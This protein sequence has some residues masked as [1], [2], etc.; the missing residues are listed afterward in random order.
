MACPAGYRPSQSLDRVRAE[1]ADRLEARLPE[2]GE[3][4]LCRLYAISD[5]TDAQ[6]AEYRE[7]LR[8]AMSAAIEYAL[9]AIERGQERSGP[10]PAAML[11]QARSAARN[12]VGLEVVLRRYAAGYSALSDFLMQETGRDSVRFPA[13]ELYPMQ[14][15]LTAL[16]D[17]IV[18]AVGAEYRQE[19]EHMHRPRA[20][21]LSERVKRLLVGELIDTAEFDYDFD[22]WHLGV[23]VT[24]PGAEHLLREHAAILNRRLLL[25]EGLESTTWAWLGGRQS[26][27]PAELAELPVPGP[28]SRVVMAIGEPAQGLGGWRLT[29]R[30]AGLALMIALRR[31]QCFVR[32]ADVALLASVLRDEDLATFLTSSYVAPLSSERDGGEAL[33][34]TL[35]AYFAAGR[36]VSSAAAVLGVT[37][38]TVTNRLRTAEQKIGRCLDTCAAEVEI[39]LGLQDCS[40]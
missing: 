37:R 33:C 11:T 2:I 30:Q 40:Q 15:E 29:H 26:F 17:R 13:A 6:N 14:R 4:I 8:A 12:R 21:R 36:S 27:D 1:V 5:S 22:A 23:I 34:R 38:H 24:G 32:Y 35:H 10:I 20:Q 16:F 3:A 19:M 18:A 28:P 31:T 39:A 9:A 25:A 7:G